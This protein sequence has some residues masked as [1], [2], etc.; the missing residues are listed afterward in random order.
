LGTG[1]VL[2]RFAEAFRLVDAGVLV[3][4]ASRDLGR[5]TAAAGKWGIER[6]HAGYESLVNDPN[7]DIV[8]NGLHNGLHCEWTIR[9]LRAGKHVLCEKPL[10][11]SADEVERMFA[12]AHANSRWLMEGFMYRFHPQLTE[13]KRRVSRG[14]IGRVLH[15]RSSRTAHGRSRDNPRFRRDAGGGA[16][17]DIGCY[18]VN[19]ARFFSGTEPQRVSAQARFDPQCNVDLT[20]CGT[21]EFPEGVTGQ[22]VCSFEAEPSYAAELIGTQ[23]RL[24]IPDPWLPPSWPT[25]LVL[26]RDG[27][28]E[29]IP[30][31]DPAI[32]RNIAA[33]FAIEV[34]QFS[35]FVHENK[36]PKFPPD[37]DA[38]EDS[39]ANACAL[40]ALAE[41]ART[42]QIVAVK[43]L[44]RQKP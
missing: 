20:F 31:E 30:V 12:A 2:N 24:L 19:L 22:F 43:P 40:D 42:G 38:E 17:L 14:D 4:V 9:A 39:R 3:A 5:A 7:I 34:Q 8:I 33:P 35:R 18:C 25:N 28:S 23:G 44:G 41:S 27:K 11:C 26:V 36:R 16:L 29:T 6:A 10:A 21:L 1:W 13:A 37:S 32:P 15:I